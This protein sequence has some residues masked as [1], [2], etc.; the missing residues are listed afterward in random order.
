MIQK[1]ARYYHTLKYLKPI[2]IYGQCLNRLHKKSKI[3]KNIKTPP[4]RKRTSSWVES[5]I[6]KKDKL[7]TKL[8]LECLHFKED[9]SD[10]KVWCDENKTRLWLYHLHYF[11][12]LTTSDNIDLVLRWINENPKFKG[13]GWEPYPLSLRIVNWIKYLIKNDNMPDKTRTTILTSLAQQIHYL[14][15]H[16]EIHIL[17]NH[18]LANAKALI[19][20]GMYFAN[21]KWLNRGFKIFHVE[22][23]EQILA[24]GAH[25]E[26]SPMY[27]AIILEDLL[28]V[29]NL[30]QCYDYRYPR[31]FVNLC[32]KMLDWLHAMC[33]PDG[34][35]ALFNDTAHNSAPS[36]HELTTYF[37]R[38]FNTYNIKNSKTLLTASGYC[39]MTHRNMVLIADVA[40]IGA[41]YQP[42]HAHADTLS[43]E[44][45]IGEER[46]LVNSGTSTYTDNNQR[47]LERSTFAHNTVVIND[48]NSSDIWKSFRVSRRA[49]VKDVILKAKTLQATHDGYWQKLKVLHKRTWQF[50]D[51]ALNIKDDIMGRGT[52]KITIVFHLHPNIDITQLDDYQFMFTRKNCAL[53][54]L[55]SEIPAKIL[56]STYHPGFNITIPNQKII[57][58]TIASIPITLTTIITCMEN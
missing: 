57:I 40:A 27:H 19:F 24:D 28:D 48:K 32:E 14:S 6:I 1:I 9:I 39:R 3:S 7:H 45:S 51:N 21:E 46:L 23:N 22:L 34:E 17:G 49:N 10:K 42:G 47:F 16:I 18:V 58:E 43:F 37:S 26:L 11:N 4:L 30:C 5:G 13:P 35:F 20:G 55:K 54:Q 38:L 50:I 52:H 15:R 41:T 29:I 33:H 2:Q 25:F 8:E 44:L 36:L 56:K 12:Y 53:A 31:T